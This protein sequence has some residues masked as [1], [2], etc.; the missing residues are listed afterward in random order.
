MYSI[1]DS[2]LQTIMIDLI[3]RMPA[4]DNRRRALLR[5]LWNDAA[6]AIISRHVTIR[7]CHRDG[8]LAVQV[9]DPRWMQ[10]IREASRLI[11]ERINRALE[12]LEFPE[13]TIHQLD[14]FNAPGTAPRPAPKPKSPASVTLPPD[15]RA[16]VDQLPES[17]QQSFIAWYQSAVLAAASPDDP[18]N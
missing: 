2:G 14:I 7:R 3:R 17:L 9:N 1:G 4:S 18:E 12:K 15:L 8:R 16:K 11:I 5:L 13:Y 6:G 10:P